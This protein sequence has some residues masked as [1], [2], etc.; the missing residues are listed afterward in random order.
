MVHVENLSVGFGDTNL[1][2]HVSFSVER[3]EI[4]AILGSSGA[5]KSTLLKHLIG[6]MT[7]R[8][9]RVEIL[10]TE[11]PGAAGV[12]P[13]FGVLF[14]SGALFGSMTL[15]EN[16]RLPL[17]KWTELG[18]RAIDSIACSKL[19]LV[20]LDGF[21]DYLPAAISGG[22]KKRAGIAR[23]LAL[24][25]ALLFL[26]EPSAGL[27]PVTS[28]AL[29]ELILILNRDLGVTLVVVTHELES[30]Y[31]V[32]HRCILLD[33]DARGIIAEGDPRELRGRSDD[34]RVQGFFNPSISG[35]E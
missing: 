19:R 16:V 4:F 2:E 1:L 21:E 29:D 14:Q 15:V 5:G 26:D 9:G 11:R 7:P 22:M 27:D 20:G 18:A 35:G 13:S 3:G 10:G 33:R 8:A 28:A 31:R 17:E 30:V 32:A 24:E 23:S 6:L 25:P 12:P 34:P